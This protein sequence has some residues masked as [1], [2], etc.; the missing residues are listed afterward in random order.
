MDTVSQISAMMSKTH[1]MCPKKPLR[2][3]TFQFGKNILLSISDIEHIN[4]GSVWK[5]GAGLSKLHSTFPMELFE[6]MFN[7]NFFPYSDTA[8]KYFGVLPKQWRTRQKCNLRIQRNIWRVVFEKNVFSSFSDIEWKYFD[9]LSNSF[10]WGFQKCNL[11]IHMIKL[12]KI[13][14]FGRSII[15]NHFRTLRE[16]VLVFWRKI[17]VAILETAF[18]VSIESFWEKKFCGKNYK[19]INT[20]GHSP[21]SFDTFIKNLWKGFQSCSVC[22]HRNIFRRHAFGK[23]FW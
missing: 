3:E 15:F 13:C 5:Y 4:F 12:V 7:L 16:Y 8:R 17:F 23:L 2:A 14:F 10:S 22:V 1:S 19:F 9:L 6:E 18:Y 21:K 11:R 20:F